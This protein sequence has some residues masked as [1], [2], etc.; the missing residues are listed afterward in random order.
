M[1]PQSSLVFTTE[2]S[3]TLVQ[4]Y[5]GRY[6]LKDFLK[7]FLAANVGSCESQLVE[8]KST[9]NVETQPKKT[10]GENHNPV[11]IKLKRQGCPD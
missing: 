4:R 6:N 8:G 9:L 7:P 11:F 2:L 3:T 10:I 5:N 1:T